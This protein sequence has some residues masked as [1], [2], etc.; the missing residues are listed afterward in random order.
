MAA[1]PTIHQC[2]FRDRFLNAPMASV[3]PALPSE[4]SASITGMP[5]SN[6]QSIYI[7]RNAAPPPACAS[8]GNRHTLPKPTADPTVAAI[9]PMRDPNC[10]LCD[11]GVSL[12]VGLRVQIYK[13][14]VKYGEEIVFL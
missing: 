12:G 6:M 9:S 10:C 1:A 5:S 8:A 7:S 4:N 3:P 14:S 2:D 13:I 11:I